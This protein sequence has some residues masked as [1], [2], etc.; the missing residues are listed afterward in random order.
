MN[1]W[2]YAECILYFCTSHSYRSALDPQC[3]VQYPVSFA[4][5][6]T[7]VDCVEPLTSTFYLVEGEEEHRKSGTKIMA[8]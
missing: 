2:A 6:Y 7:F 1:D 3:L 8:S 5:F 4:S